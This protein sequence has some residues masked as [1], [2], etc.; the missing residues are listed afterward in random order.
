M[1]LLNGDHSPKLS[2]WSP[3]LINLEIVYDPFILYW[4]QSF[5]LEGVQ[6]LELFE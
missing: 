2:R 6:S 1:E 5:V 3:E 4:A